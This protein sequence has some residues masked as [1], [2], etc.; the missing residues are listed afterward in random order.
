VKRFNT[1]RIEKL[2]RSGVQLSERLASLR[3]MG[4]GNWE[5]PWNPRSVTV[6]LYWGD[7]GGAFIWSLL[8]RETPVPFTVFF[9]QSDSASSQQDIVA[10]SW[11]W[12]KV[13]ES[14]GYGINFIHLIHT[15]NNIL[16]NKFCTMIRELFQLKTCRAG[17]LWEQKVRL[18][19]L[20]WACFMH[21]NKSF[22]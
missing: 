17:V 8:C 22:W 4:G 11:S 13:P 7:K 3:I 19:P 12:K 1:I 21:N 18:T 10:C 14:F 5:P 15:N 20:F 9:F 2:Q 16:G 6:L